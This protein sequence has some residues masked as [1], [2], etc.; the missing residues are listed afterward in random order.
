M[1]DPPVCQTK[2]QNG[3]WFDNCLDLKHKYGM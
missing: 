1:K 3:F 2:F